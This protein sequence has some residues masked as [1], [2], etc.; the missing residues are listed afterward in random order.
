MFNGSAS[1]IEECDRSMADYKESLSRGE[2]VDIEN[3]DGIYII[4]NSGYSISKGKRYKEVK[5]I[6]Q[7][8]I[9]DKFYEED[10][11]KITPFSD[12]SKIERSP[13]S[14]VMSQRILNPPL[15]TSSLSEGCD[16]IFKPYQFRPL[17]KFIDNPYSRILVC[18]ETGLGKTIEAGYIIL[19]EIAKGAENIV[20][21]CPS[22]L[23]Y[24]WYKELIK[25]FGLDFQIKRLDM[26]I[27]ELSSDDYTRSIISVDSMREDHRDLESSLSYDEDRIDLLIIDEA[28]TVKNETL[29]RRLGEYLS[30]ISD[31]VVGLTA[32]PIHTGRE[33][34]KE[35]MKV[36]N[37]R[38]NTL[39]DEMF[40][41]LFDF[42]RLI[43]EWKE[44]IGEENHLDEILALLNDMNSDGIDWLF[45]I[46]R[47][48]KW[49]DD[50]SERYVNR[51]KRE[52][53][54]VSSQIKEI[55]PLYKHLNRTTRGDV[56]EDRERSVEDIQVSLS[57]D[58]KSFGE[59]SV[60][61]ASLFDKIDCLLE[62]NFSYVH[63][64]QLESS[65]PA[66]RGLLVAGKEGKDK[67]KDGG[68]C[69]L[70]LPEEY[71]E[72]DGNEVP[73]LDEDARDQC[74][75]MLDLM[76]MIGK[77]S[78]WSALKDL[79]HNLKSNE[80]H[81][82]VIVFTHWRPT[83]E[84]FKR[85][86]EE[87]R[88]ECFFITGEDP[89]WLRE[90]K[91]DEFDDHEYFSIIFA[92]DVLSE[93]LDLQSADCVINYDIP[94]EPSTLEQRIGRIDRIGQESEKIYIYNIWTGHRKENGDGWELTDTGKRTLEL[95]FSR[96]QDIDEYIGVVGEI[97]EMFTTELLEG[98]LP[99]Y[100]YD[101]EKRE[102]Y[103]QILESLDV[104]TPIL[105]EEG[106][107]S[108]SKGL[109]ATR[110]ATLFNDFLMTVEG[111][112]VSLEEQ[113]NGS[114]DLSS[115]DEE[116][117]SRI[118]GLAPKDKRSE[119]KDF[120]WNIKRRED[121]DL[122]FTK[123]EEGIFL[124]MNHPLMRTASR[125]ILESYK[126]NGVIPVEVIEV[127][128]I[129]NIVYKSSE[130]IDLPIYLMEVFLKWED[131]EERHWLWSVGEEHK[132]EQMLSDID[133]KRR[134]M[135]YDDENID[136]TPYGFEKISEKA[137]DLAEKRFKDMKEKLIDRLNNAIA[138]ERIR[139]KTPS[140]D[141]EEKLDEI[142]NLDI[143]EEFSSDNM[144]TRLILIIKNS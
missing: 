10:F 132:A 16:V 125:V 76:E 35:I 43:S 47:V 77:D 9:T 98:V 39:N 57:T 97:T 121:I 89:S 124:P 82:K 27:D 40:W 42:S 41:Q 60:S 94:T 142:E 80:D 79:L 118:A 117:I 101:D 104:F 45:D 73:A 52:E 29:R 21:V 66:I 131:L 51:V 17:I 1:N 136:K 62:D 19:R 26:L 139:R 25:R 78:K 11:K 100:D 31:G 2:L 56:G 84:Y 107:S 3:R 70:D 46:D 61:E 96:Q 34:L 106:V 137:L 12:K 28:H 32:T 87:L 36:I 143:D 14:L 90:K 110:R 105:E 95:L 63:R 122:S 4:I 75:R 15:G 23:R 112:E 86:H 103:I 141:L 129:E 74:R 13:L 72:D 130:S 85:R 5:K 108:K 116:S 123:S 133:I 7:E 30:M 48:E 33:D 91:V 55:H 92:T 59:Y 68:S 54:P 71:R 144:E 93:G 134:Y 127:D 50:V 99:G 126:K 102:E 49:I 6:G 69:F 22:S 53:V 128:N 140:E 81:D 88:S 135:I 113:E 37:P 119:I 83:M 20:V 109:I 8:E 18:D 38:F 24:K 44:K 65:L 58:V 115:L 114:Y 67:W 64:R 111:D 120:L 138:S